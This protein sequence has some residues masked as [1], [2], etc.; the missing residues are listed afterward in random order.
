MFSK[1]SVGEAVR[2]HELP[3]QCSM[4]TLKLFMFPTAQHS[5]ADAQVTAARWLSKMAHARVPQKS[6][7]RFG[8]ATMV[9]EVPFHRSMRVATAEGSSKSPVA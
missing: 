6:T 3:S 9:Q 7:F 1:P 8:E 5:D 2:D 4:R